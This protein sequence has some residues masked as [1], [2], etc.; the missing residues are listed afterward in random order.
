MKFFQSKDQHPY[1]SQSEA[2][3]D[4]IYHVVSKSQR[5]IHGVEERVTEYLALG[6][7]SNLT[8]YVSKYHFYIFNALSAYK[9]VRPC[10]HK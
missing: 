2:E 10:L 3:F 9:D 6:F 1:E 7:N 4:D 5:Q 8:E